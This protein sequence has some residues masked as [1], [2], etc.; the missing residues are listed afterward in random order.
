MWQEL[1]DYYL[2]RKLSDTGWRGLAARPIA[3]I[4][5]RDSR[6]AQLW[7]AP[8]LPQLGLMPYFGFH[9]MFARLLRTDPGFRD[10]WERTVKISARRPHNLLIHGLDRPPSPELLAELEQRQVPLYKL[11]WRVDPTTLPASS[12]VNA[13]LAG[14]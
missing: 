2:G 11:N 1:A 9:Y 10:I 4:L 12:A 7:F 3:R 8:P 5:N 13:L 14:Y 6:L